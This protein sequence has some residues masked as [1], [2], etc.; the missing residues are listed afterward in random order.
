MNEFVYEVRQMPTRDLM[1]ILEDQVDLYSEEELLI[2]CSS[3]APP[4]NGQNSPM[5]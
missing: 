3:K 5:S 1:L 2:P 4:M